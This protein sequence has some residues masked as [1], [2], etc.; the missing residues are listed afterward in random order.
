[1]L[2][3]LGLMRRED[4]EETAITIPMGNVLGLNVPGSNTDPL[5]EK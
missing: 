3:T 2:N 5:T 1:M 4:P